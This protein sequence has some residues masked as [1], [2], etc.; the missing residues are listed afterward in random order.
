MS[1]NTDVIV[2]DPDGMRCHDCGRKHTD[3]KDA[4]SHAVN[5]P[6]HSGIIERW[7]CSHCGSVT[8]GGRR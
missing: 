6:Y 5:G 4:G 3:W 1:E 2:D 8:E 7:E